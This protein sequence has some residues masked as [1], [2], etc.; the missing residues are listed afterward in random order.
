MSHGD[1]KGVSFYGFGCLSISP[2]PHA[3]TNILID[4]TG[5][6][7]I[8][9]FGLLVIISD[10]S[11]ASSSSS[12]SQGGTARWMSPE[13]ID[14][15]HF[16]L[17]H[18]RPTKSS[19]CYALGMVIYET[20][21]GHRPF[22]EYVDFTVPLKVS[23]GKRPP[24]GDRFTDTLWEM[25]EQCWAHQPNARPSIEDL[26]QYLEQSSRPLDSPHPVID[27]E[28]NQRAGVS[29]SMFPSFNV[30][31][32]QRIPFTRT[33][34]IPQDHHWCIVNCWILPPQWT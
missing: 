16:G 4:Q 7:C 6:A 31:W 30:L 9:D 33:M 24:R 2:S 20:I 21:S 17:N 22:H 3:K 25:L 29:S 34:F 23:Q 18:S 32:S 19:D 11:N 12:C 27:K 8:A 10:P 1:L 13:L 28:V 15:Q 5:H 14:P 26:L